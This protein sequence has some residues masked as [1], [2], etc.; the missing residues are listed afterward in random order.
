MLQQVNINLFAL[1]PSSRSIVCL[2]QGKS[3]AFFSVSKKSVPF[4]LH[5]QLTIIQ[6]ITQFT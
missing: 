2:D 1:K 5:G 3:I 4:N 6:Y